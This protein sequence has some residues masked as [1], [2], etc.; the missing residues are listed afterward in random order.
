MPSPLDFLH[1]N[2][3]QDEWAKRYV[4]NKMGIQQMQEGGESRQYSKGELSDYV[5]AGKQ[6]YVDAL[7]FWDKDTSLYDSLLKDVQLGNIVAQSLGEKDWFD[8][9]VPGYIKDIPPAKNI[10]GVFKSPK[11]GGSEE[12][13]KDSIFVRANSPFSGSASQILGHELAHYFTPHKRGMLKPSPLFPWEYYIAGNKGWKEANELMKK[14]SREE[15]NERFYPVAEKYKDKIYSELKEKSEKMKKAGYKLPKGMQEG[16]DPEMPWGQKAQNAIRD[17]RM[18]WLAKKDP[19][20]RAYLDDTGI[21]NWQGAIARGRSSDKFTEDNEG[22]LSDFIS[23]QSTEFTK[24]GMK[25][26]ILRNIMKEQI[27]DGNI[28]GDFSEEF[29]LET[30]K[31]KYNLEQFNPLGRIRMQQEG[32]YQYGGPVDEDDSWKKAVE[33]SQSQL[34]GQ[35]PNKYWVNKI[36][37][38]AGNITD[39]M[40]VP[41]EPESNRELNLDESTVGKG[42]GYEFSN[43]EY[44]PVFESAPADETAHDQ[45]NNLIFENEMK[46]SQGASPF[47]FLNRDRIDRENQE[48]MDAVMGSVLPAAG[49]VSF[50]KGA[51]PMLELIKKAQKSKDFPMMKSKSMENY[52]RFRQQGLDKSAKKSLRNVDWIDF[53]MNLLK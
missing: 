48:L 39:V 12:G 43:R 28:L 3:N 34:M 13:S 16:G 1:R 23:D 46:Q 36:Y 38:E 19:Q 26:A 53:Y 50:G 30:D 29:S 52:L 45:M 8:K 2:N 6:D 20:L 40:G 42:G 25:G 9:M 5:E 15:F 17:M 41:G 27:K 18:G 11:Y 51:K 31:G 33:L 49:A 32:G 10:S 21:E 14:T 7:K 44:S 4:G 22:A 35:W 37:D 24:G 47:S